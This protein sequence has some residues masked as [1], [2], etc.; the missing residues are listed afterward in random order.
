M[1]IGACER[2]EE[3]DLGGGANGSGDGDAVLVGGCFHDDG[4]AP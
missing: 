1:D 3:G 4:W 2:V